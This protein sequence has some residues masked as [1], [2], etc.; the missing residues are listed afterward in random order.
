MPAKFADSKDGKSTND[1]NKDLFGLD[2]D[3]RNGLDDDE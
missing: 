2:D 3:G 1:N